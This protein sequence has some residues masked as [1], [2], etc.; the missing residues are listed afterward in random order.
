M[1]CSPIFVCFWP[2]LWSFSTSL[3][4]LSEFSFS[5]PGFGA[6]FRDFIFILAVRIGILLG[7]LLDLGKRKLVQKPCLSGVLK[8]GPDSI[9][10][11]AWW[12]KG[13]FSSIRRRS[14]RN[15]GPFG[16]LN[17]TLFELLLH[18]SFLNLSDHPG[19]LSSSSIQANFLD[20][21]RIKSTW[22]P[23]GTCGLL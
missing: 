17:A 2:N 22:K 14:S 9:F 15:T 8:R 3:D 19:P 20:E 6:N 12:K 10:E 16:F 18:Y 21:K 7:V 4:R 13:N 1:A 11:L 5:I 23:G